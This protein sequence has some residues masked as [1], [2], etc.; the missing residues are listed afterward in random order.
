ML[1]E[2]RTCF[3]EVILSFLFWSTG[4]WGTNISFLFFS[5]V[6]FFSLACLC[7]PRCILCKVRGKGP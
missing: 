3:L 5:F 6:F 7:V 1:L 4:W 2:L